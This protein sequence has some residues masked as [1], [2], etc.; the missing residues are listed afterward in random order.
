MTQFSKRL[1][2]VVSLLAPAS[3][4][5]SANVE[6]TNNDKN[7]N[8]V[9]TRSVAI[10]ANV[11]VNAIAYVKESL[12]SAALAINAGEILNLPK[13]NEYAYPSSDGFIF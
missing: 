9:I 8:N 5:R 10:S 11:K 6:Q 7:N 13:A 3:C 12:F 2:S 4:G 1:N